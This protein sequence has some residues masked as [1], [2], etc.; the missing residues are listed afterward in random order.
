MFLTLNITFALIQF[1]IWLIQFLP[2]THPLKG[3]DFH[4]FFVIYVVK[5][6]PVFFLNQEPKD[7]NKPSFLFLC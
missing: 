4:R 5:I 2:W 3:L 6:T 1:V 7:I